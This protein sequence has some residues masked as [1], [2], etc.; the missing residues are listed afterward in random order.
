MKSLKLKILVPMLVV[1]LI[2]LL[3]VSGI[4]YYVGKVQLEEDIIKENGLLIGKKAE[5]INTWLTEFAYMLNTVADTNLISGIDEAKE[6]EVFSGL[7]KKNSQISDIYMGLEDGR[8]I[9]GSGWTPPAD[10]TPKTRVWYQKGI[11][12]SGVAF[13][14]PY[15]D[16]ITGNFV[17]S[18]VRTIYFAD[19]TKRGV[20]GA[21]I[22]L[23]EISKMVGEIKVGK[24]DY[25]FL[26]DANGVTIA[27]PN[28]ESLNLNVTENEDAEIAKMGKAVLK[29]T[30]GTVHYK[31]K[32]VDRVATFSTVPITGWK[33]VVSVPYNE[34]NESIA[35]L[36]LI[37]AVL[38]IV[39]LL[40]ITLVVWLLAS[41]ITKPIISLNQAAQELSEGNLT[42]TVVVKSND[43]L[44]QLA[45]SFNTISKNMRSMI[46]GTIALTNS[47][48]K[49]TQ[50]VSVAS[51]QTTK[52][53]QQIS[54]AITDLASGADNQSASV[55]KGVEMV[56]KMGNALD[57]I[58]AN[59]ENVTQASE[60]MSELIGQGVE[61]V[62]QQNKMME[63]SSNATFNVAKAICALDEKSKQIGQIIEVIDSIASQTNLLALNAAI[64]AARAG[65]QGR[66]FAVVADEVRKLAE[67]ST[68]ATEKINRLISEI[69]LGTE[70]AVKEMKFTETVVKEQENSTMRV[71][72]VFDTIAESVGQIGK[73]FR[74]VTQ[75][76]NMI[77][78]EVKEIT[79]VINS[80]ANVAENNAAS[81]EE[82]AASTQ[83]QVASLEDISNTLNDLAR[84]SEELK[85]ALSKFKI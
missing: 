47:I 80:I 27:H 57:A 16:L 29:G 48:S 37:T 38:I 50:Q 5:E 61:A 13:S 7:L 73:K 42:K 52:I 65:E 46:S 28:K 11:S 63:Q 64:E 6:K 4:F 45:Q 59:S 40:V 21:D 12:A 72:Q 36:S 41:S 20:I 22:S 10:Y 56:T 3:S 44:G 60:H 18:P 75:E 79:Q 83:E 81:S 35:K 1:S 9:D 71:G 84:M 70:T 23:A 74:D 30:E 82:V 58:I 68:E 32:G 33:L 69:R 2:I 8:F 14:E 66:G 54:E 53:S 78:N 34:I 19:G 76:T 24:T 85:A 51:E 77:D 31:Y 62:I 26:L 43:E 17:V 15:I 67:Q 49:S 55:Q 39:G 25:A